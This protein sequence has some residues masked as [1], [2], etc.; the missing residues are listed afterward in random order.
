LRTKIAVTM[1]TSTMSELLNELNWHSTPEWEWDEESVGEEE[2][3]DRE[4]T[5]RIHNNLCEQSVNWGPDYDSEDPATAELTREEWEFI[6]R[7][8]PFEAQGAIENQA[9]KKESN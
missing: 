3:G 2:P 7:F 8:G 1:P 4:T 9:F 6:Y 5:L